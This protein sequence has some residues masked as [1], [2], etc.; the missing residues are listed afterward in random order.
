[1]HY[2]GRMGKDGEAMQRF[3]QE[4]GV[5]NIRFHGAYRPSDRYAFIAQ[6]DL[7]HNVFDLDRTMTHAVSN[8]YYDGLIFRIPQLCAKGSYMGRLVMKN[9]V[10]CAVDFLR[11]DI[12]DQIANYYYTL[13][14]DRFTACCEQTLETVFCN[15]S[16]YS[17]C[18]MTGKVTDSPL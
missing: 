4:N 7:V 10:G 8:K 15:R 17:V 16:R 13:Q 5:E 12:A 1:M 9:G 14:A 3:A 6:T 2:Y 18:S 11:E